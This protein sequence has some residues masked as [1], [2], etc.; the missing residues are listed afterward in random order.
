MAP[1]PGSIAHKIRHMRE[2]RKKAISLTNLTQLH[3]LHSKQE[4]RRPRGYPDLYDARLHHISDNKAF[5]LI[6][7]LVIDTNIEL[8]S[9]VK[10]PTPFPNLRNLCLRRCTLY[11]LAEKAY[12]RES[13]D[14]Y[15]DSLRQGPRDYAM[16]WQPPTGRPLWIM[17]PNLQELELRFIP[18]H[19]RSQYI[20]FS[21]VLKDLQ[22]GMGKRLKTLHLS[23]RPRTRDWRLGYKF[24]VKQM[25]FMDY[26]ILEHLALEFALLDPL[27]RNEYD[28][29]KQG[30]R[31]DDLEQ[32]HKIRL[33]K[34]LPPSLRTLAIHH[35]ATDDSP[36]EDR[37]L[38]RAVEGI[39]ERKRQF[40]PNLHR[41]DIWREKSLDDR[42][43]TQT[44][45]RSMPHHWRVELQSFIHC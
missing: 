7:V 8:Y 29:M 45:P 25:E 17:F 5:T 1:S 43:A 42:Q 21:S 4:R 6:R 9:H 40:H 32:F 44:I 35:L 22:E 23:L 27:P 30:A 12:P 16:D 18:N 2:L 3:I 31:H 33:S 28:L 41:I 11:Y 19:E 15:V 24:H 14:T 20:D 38:D 10:C 13:D 36:T 34:V 26:S 37:N 39:K